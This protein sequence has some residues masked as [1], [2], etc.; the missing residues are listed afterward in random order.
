MY[1]IYH[2]DA[3]KLREITFFSY[4]DIPRTVAAPEASFKQNGLREYQL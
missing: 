1:L 3:R 4:L 2:R